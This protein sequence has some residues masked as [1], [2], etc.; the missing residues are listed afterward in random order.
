MSD[1]DLN[2]PIIKGRMPEPEPLSMEEYLQFVEFM[3]KEMPVDWEAY[4]KEKKL[5]AVNVPFRIE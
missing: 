5:S 3:L 1:I 2:L 4:D